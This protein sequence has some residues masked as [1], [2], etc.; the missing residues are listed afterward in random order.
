M[1]NTFL[2]CS[3]DW[4]ALQ[5]PLIER[6]SSV[7]HFSMLLLYLLMIF[8]FSFGVEV[9]GLVDF[10]IHL[11]VWSHQIRL[12]MV[13]RVVSLDKWRNHSPLCIF[14]LL[15]KSDRI[16]KKSELRCVLFFSLWHWLSLQEDICFCD[17][18]VGFW[19]PYFSQLARPLSTSVCEDS[20]WRVKRVALMD[21]FG[22]GMGCSAASDDKTRFARPWKASEE[23]LCLASRFFLHSNEKRLSWV[24]GLLLLILVFMVGFC[25]DLF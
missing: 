3:F 2:L 21:D 7:Q 10:P 18:A 19:A 16:V 17:L 12:E 6:V 8:T 20:A 9:K 23:L 1:F 5:N 4:T 15:R 24:S 22:V 14:L 25:L 13:G 11:T